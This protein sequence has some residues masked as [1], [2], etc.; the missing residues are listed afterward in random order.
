MHERYFCL[1]NDTIVRLEGL[2]KLNVPFIFIFNLIL[3]LNLNLNLNLKVLNTH[4]I[5][6]NYEGYGRVYNIATLQRW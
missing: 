1:K 4:S 5:E 2:V 3:N 6:E